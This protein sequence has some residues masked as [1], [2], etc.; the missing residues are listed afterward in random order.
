MARDGA[1]APARS[2]RGLLRSARSTGQQQPSQEYRVASGSNTP[3]LTDADLASTLGDVG[4]YL[5]GSLHVLPWLAFRG[6]VRTDM[7][8]FDVLNNC[9]VQSVDNPSKASPEINAPCLSELDHGV[10]REPFQRSTTA[11]GAIMPRGTVILG[12]VQHFEFAASA[13]NG[14]RSVDPSYVS[15]GLQTPFASVESRD[16]GVTYTGNLGERTTLAAKSVFFQ[17]HVDEDL[18][19]DPTQGRNTLANGTTRTGWSELSADA[20]AASSTS[21]PTQRS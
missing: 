14:V 7:F 15:Q 8:L 9:A 6:G 19:F 2:G 20:G 17:T 21:P 18:L 16:L 1:R 5:D 4:V 11:S 3:Y 10:Y 13:G 12:P